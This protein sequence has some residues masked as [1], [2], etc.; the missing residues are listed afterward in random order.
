[1]RKARVLPEERAGAEQHAAAAVVDDLWNQPIVE[2]GRI[3]E[4]LDAG[5]DRQQPASRQPEAVKDRQRVEHA[6]L[7][8]EVGDRPDLRDVGENGA[9]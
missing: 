7:H 9:V 2:R 4:Q 8:R 6:V 1:M 5:Q 3:Q